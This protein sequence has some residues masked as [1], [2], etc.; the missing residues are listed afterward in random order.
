MHLVLHSIL[1]LF[2]IIAL[3]WIAIRIRLIE[4]M[5]TVGLV[6]YVFYIATPALL[7]RALAATVLPAEW[8]IALWLCYFVPAVSMLLLGSLASRW[9]FRRPAPAAIVTGFASAFSNGVLI[10]APVVLGSY[11]KDAALPYFLIISLHSPLL[12]PLATLGL[13]LAR[14]NQGGVGLAA[15]ECLKHLSRNPIILALATGL[16]L[17]SSGIKLWGPVLDTLDLLADSAAPTALFATGAQLAQYQIR[18]AIAEALMVST[19]KLLVMP[20]LVAFMGTQVFN[21]PPLWLSVACTVAALPS[22]VNAYLLGN[23][24]Q[25]G[26]E[27]A[28]TAIVLSTALSMVSLSLCLW[29]FRPG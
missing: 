25:A 10:G 6:T 26:L 18:G 5:A 11:G 19:L 21:L 23:R 27:V 9:L 16:L 28:T 3:G 8:P 20:L 15:R 29:W 2:S 24:Y 7:I 1:P 13:E 4:E 14:G 17:N 22:G 12:F